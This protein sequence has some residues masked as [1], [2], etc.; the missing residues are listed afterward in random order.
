MNGTEGKGFC[1]ICI[2]HI[3]IEPPYTVTIDYNPPL[4]NNTVRT[5]G[6]HTWLYFTYYH[7]EHEVMIIHMPISPS[8]KIAFWS[9]WWF[10]TIIALAVIVVVLLSLSIKQKKAIQA[11]ERELR[12]HLYRGRALFKADV[13]KR[14][15]KIEEFKKKYNMEIR[16]ADTLED[17]FKRWEFEK[18]VKH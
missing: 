14:R 18:R 3:L 12:S 1:R 5:N 15:A 16:T 17:F 9:E 13:K 4:Y 11:Y 8:E 2:P 7:S 10:W 6:T